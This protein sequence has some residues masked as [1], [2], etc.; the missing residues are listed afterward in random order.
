VDLAWFVFEA[1]L[2]REAVLFVAFFGAA[3][4]VVFLA[5]LLVDLL[6]VFGAERGLFREEEVLLG[7]FFEAAFLAALFLAVDF[8]AV[9][10]EAVLPVF[11][12]VVR[13]ELF[14]AG[15]RAGLMAAGR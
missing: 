14:L 9:F 4:F 12:A 7:V 1:V 5:D 2:F 3:F 10:R 13:F 6:A 8:L 11:L 15:F